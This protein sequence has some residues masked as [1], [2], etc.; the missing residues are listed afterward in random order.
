MSLFRASRFVA[1]VLAWFHVIIVDAKLQTG[2]I[3]LS[4]TDQ[5]GRWHYVSKFGYA[6]GLGTYEVRA[7]EK[8]TSGLQVASSRAEVE[9]EVYLDEQWVL[10]ESLP[11]CQRASGAPAKRVLDLP[12]GSVPGE[13]G[14]WVAGELQQNVRPHIWYFAL[15]NCRAITS[16][17]HQEIEYEVRLRQSDGSEYSFE[18]LHMVPS[19]VLIIVVLTVV[20][21]VFLTRVLRVRCETDVAHPAT[22]ALLASLSLLWAAQGLHLAHLI[23]YRFDGIGLWVVD[24]CSEVLFTLSHVL[25]AT[26]L[27]AIA[28]GYALSPS[29]TCNLRTLAPIAT[30]VGFAKVLLVGFGKL[31]GETAQTHHVNEGAVGWILLAVR[32]LLYVWFSSSARALAKRSGLRLQA[33]LLYFQVAGAVYFLAYPVIFGIVQALA[34][35]LRHPVQQI[36][37]VLLQTGSALW[38]S[39]MLLGRGTF[40]E[41]STLGSSLLPGGSPVGIGCGGAATCLFP[42]AAKQD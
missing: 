35:Y 5:E 13:W 11:G 10:A 4:A 16:D 18:M 41:I 14:P 36:G 39:E 28:K 34:P 30:V 19:S 40:Y 26:L 1:S 15:S 9:L 12:L 21:V 29:D 20:L 37:L 22:W 27:I 42:V 17:T 32:V 38:L 6:I 25:T 7:R 33:F 31:Q 2:S 3:S 24:A 8:Q 23:A